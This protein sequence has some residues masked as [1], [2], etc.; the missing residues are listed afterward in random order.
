[1]KLEEIYKVNNKFIVYLDILGFEEL[2]E[3][4]EKNENIR[5]ER[6]RKDLFINPLQKKIQKWMKREFNKQ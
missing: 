3:K 6:V 2:A 4:I 1:M 5:S